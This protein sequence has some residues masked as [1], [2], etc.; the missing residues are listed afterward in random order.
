[1]IGIIGV[2]VAVHYRL[3]KPLRLTEVVVVLPGQVIPQL[4]ALMANADFSTPKGR[5]KALANLAA[6][7][8]PE[9]VR[10]G[11]VRFRG[12]SKSNSIHLK[13]SVS[14][15]RE[16]MAAAGLRER[17]PAAV[18]DER[19]QEASSPACV[20]GIIITV[21]AGEPIEE[22]DKVEACVLL[23]ALRERAS[24]RPLLLYLYYAPEPQ[25]QLSEEQARTM[26]RSLGSGGRGEGNRE[27]KRRRASI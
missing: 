8:P 10:D 6:V 18:I 20:L 17:D 13:T 25:Q 22:G 9:C 24:P 15:Y 27:E 21:P 1:V 3:K 5:R 12:E 4:D 23:G 26:L 14:L 16:R 2:A 11:W 19:A 7:V